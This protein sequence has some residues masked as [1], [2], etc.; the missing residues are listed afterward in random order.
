METSNILNG[1]A[2]SP[3]SALKYRSTAKD[4]H[5]DENK[6]NIKTN[7]NTAAGQT[8][9]Q[10]RSSFKKSYSTADDCT[11]KGN[12]ATP[13]PDIFM[14]KINSIIRTKDRFSNNNNNNNNNNNEKPQTY[15]GK[16]YIENGK[17]NYGKMLTDEVLAADYKL[18]EAAKKTVSF[19]FEKKRLKNVLNCH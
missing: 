12:C 9:L 14:D 7:E 10:R 8:A 19:S 4:C 5:D 11:T 17:I 18:V 16:C 15:A 13:Q 3:E 6:E 1:I 2:E